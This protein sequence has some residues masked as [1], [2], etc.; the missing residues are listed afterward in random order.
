MLT[1]GIPL[2]MRFSRRTLNSFTW[3]LQDCFKASLSMIFIFV[4]TSRRSTSCIVYFGKMQPNE[5]LLTQNEKGERTRVPAELAVV[6]CDVSRKGVNHH[7]Y[8]VREKCGAVFLN[9]FASHS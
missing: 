7:R 8:F 2:A 9:L 1:Y 6:G 5:F 4:F 3:V